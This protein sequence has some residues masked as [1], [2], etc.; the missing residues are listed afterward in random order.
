[1]RKS[2]IA[3]ILI[4]YSIAGLSDPLFASGSSNS[5]FKTYVDPNLKEDVRN[6]LSRLSMPFALHTWNNYK[7]G[8]PKDIKELK[9]FIRDR[10][11]QFDIS[12]YDYL[13]VKKDFMGIHY[14]AR[15]KGEKELISDTITHE[16]RKQLKKKHYR[17]IVN[18]LNED[19][20]ELALSMLDEMAS[21]HK[22]D[23]GVQ[24]LY[25]AFR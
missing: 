22:D 20:K 17:M 24:L 8:V 16:E 14:S 3:L 25:R 7:G 10:E 15:I 2:V 23:L 13:E 6:V 19:G 4:I 12:D 1:M 21:R 5:S 9:A 11:L 18:V